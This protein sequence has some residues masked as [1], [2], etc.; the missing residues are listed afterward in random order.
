MSTT[1]SDVQALL[2][3][4]QKS[5]E[6]VD[7]GV[8]LVSP[9]GARLVRPPKAGRSSTWVIL[10]ELTPENAAWP[11][12]LWSQTVQRQMGRIGVHLGKVTP[13]GPM[14]RYA[15]LVGVGAPA[16]TVGS[17]ESAL[18]RGADGGIMAQATMQEMNMSFN[19]QYLSLQ[20]QM[21]HENRR[22]TTLSNV[23]KTRH[24]TAKNAINNLR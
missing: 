2:S 13:T 15:G 17:A 4:M 10:A 19:L 22:Y 3:A 18:S 8:A 24:D 21:Q 11:E 6:M 5:P 1:D 14:G 7:A 16:G 20:Q 12:T 23:M 9:A